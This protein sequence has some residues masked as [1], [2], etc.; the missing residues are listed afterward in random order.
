MPVS[1]GTYTFYTTSD[2]GAPWVN[3]QQMVNN[4]AAHASTERI[5]A[6]SH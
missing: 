6:L 4:R 1:G 5:K 2:D 3:G